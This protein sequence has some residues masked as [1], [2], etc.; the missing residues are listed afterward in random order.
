[1]VD[2]LKKGGEIAV[3][4]L[5]TPA[6]ISAVFFATCTGLLLSLI[7]YGLSEL[8]KK[9]TYVKPVALLYNGIIRII[10][11]NFLR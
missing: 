11:L 7:A 3:L 4:V 9:S 5:F 10:I 6:V 1:M 2:K 8:K